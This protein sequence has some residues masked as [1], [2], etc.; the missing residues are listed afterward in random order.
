MAV[1][2][3]KVNTASDLNDLWYLM[4]EVLKNPD[5]QLLY[6]R[7]LLLFELCFDKVTRF[8]KAYEEAGGYDSPED[9]HDVCPVKFGDIIPHQRSDAEYYQL[10]RAFHH[11][12]RTAGPKSKLDERRRTRAVFIASDIATFLLV[13]ED[14][15][16]YAIEKGT[17]LLRQAH[18]P[19]GGPGEVSY[20]NQP[21]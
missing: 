21:N 20:W 8:H 18:F 13:N 4:D 19:E 10:G 9:I 1:S 3:P 7:R 14:H 2:C 11:L 5:M 15:A 17:K 16:R 6:G 12:E